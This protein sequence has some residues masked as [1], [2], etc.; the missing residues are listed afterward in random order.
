MEE[1]EGR[2][3]AETPTWTVA[4]VITVMVSLG[5]FLHSSL[6]HF[7]KVQ[8]LILNSSSYFG[9]INSLILDIDTYIYIYMSPYL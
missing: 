8:S 2:S 4:T 9:F 3:L 6:K 1:R 5:F 7:G